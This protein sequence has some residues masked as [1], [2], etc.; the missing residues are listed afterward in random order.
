[1]CPCSDPR[2]RLLSIRQVVAEDPLLYS[3]G[4]PMGGSEDGCA[5]SGGTGSVRPDDDADGDADGSAGMLIEGSPTR[6]DHQPPD[7]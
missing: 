5:S 3:L 6:T 1:M 2:P 7:H 4:A